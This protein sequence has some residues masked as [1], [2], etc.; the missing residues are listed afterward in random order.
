MEY[1]FATNYRGQ[2]RYMFRFLIDARC[3]QHTYAPGCNTNSKPASSRQES[4]KLPINP[5][6]ARITHM[7]LKASKGAFH[8][9]PVGETT[10]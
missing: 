5:E 6:A 10:I 9:A 3:A 4:R 8:K 7:Q 2:P 1:C